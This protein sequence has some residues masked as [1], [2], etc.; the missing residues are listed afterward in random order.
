M[1]GGLGKAF[2]TLWN[3]TQEAYSVWGPSEFRG[4]SFNSKRRQVLLKI[5]RFY[6]GCNLFASELLFYLMDFSQI[7]DH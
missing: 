6:I 5:A 2:G 4:S 3:I 7:W 1:Q